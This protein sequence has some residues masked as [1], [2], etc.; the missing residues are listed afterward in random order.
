M[1]RNLS[2]LT[3]SALIASVLAIQLE[4]ATFALPDRSSFVLYSSINSS[5]D[6][7]FRRGPPELLI[8]TP[9]GQD[10]YLAL[11]SYNVS[12]PTENMNDGCIPQ[13]DTLTR[14]CWLQADLER[15]RPTEYQEHPEIYL[16]NMTKPIIPYHMPE[17][18]NSTA[19]NFTL[20]VWQQTPELLSYLATISD[21]KDASKIGSFNP[22]EG[23]E[24]AEFLLKSYDL[25]TYSSEVA[26]NSTLMEIPRTSIDFEVESSSNTTVSWSAPAA[27]GLKLTGQSDNS[28]RDFEDGTSAGSKLGLSKTGICGLATIVAVLLVL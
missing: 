14:W 24:K 19:Y 5:Q 21:M 25:L 13:P 23:A 10:K 18:A 26:G 4:T 8:N 1:F 20:Q 15:K 12:S 17:L 27:I 22:K 6:I 7:F 16:Q 9:A 3:S 11:L 28:Q 2:I